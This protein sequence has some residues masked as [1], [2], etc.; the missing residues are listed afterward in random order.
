MR[1]R[2]LVVTLVAPALLA[3]CLGSP[4]PYR[5]YGKGGVREERPDPEHRVEEEERLALKNA[6]PV[7][8]DRTEA[9]LEQGRKAVG[10]ILA[11]IPRNPWNEHRRDLVTAIG[12][13]EAAKYLPK[14]PVRPA[15][16]APAEGPAEGEGEGEG[17]GGEEE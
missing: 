16:A 11:S 4:E 6:V 7:E 8:V 1:P 14:D 17:E 2:P 5:P 3:G 15:G 12:P 10:R 9:S 13:D